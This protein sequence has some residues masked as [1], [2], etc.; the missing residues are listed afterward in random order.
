MAVAHCVFRP[1]PTLAIELA[2]RGS[3]WPLLD[4]VDH[5]P[6]A[7]FGLV[8]QILYFWRHARFRAV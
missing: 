8:R 2:I 4:P 7:R 5:Q 1:Q 6:S 3:S